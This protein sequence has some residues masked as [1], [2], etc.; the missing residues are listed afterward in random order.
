MRRNLNHS[1]AFADWR[2]RIDA[3]IAISRW[4]PIFIATG[5]DLVVFAGWFDTRPKRPA[6]DNGRR[7]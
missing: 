4:R 3:A 2:A 6:N 7:T 1:D 5:D